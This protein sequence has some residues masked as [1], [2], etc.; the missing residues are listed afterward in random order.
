MLSFASSAR[1]I[2]S[3]REAKKKRFFFA[4]RKEAMER[5]PNALAK[6]KKAEEGKL[7]LQV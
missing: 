2:A 4:S 6:E 1:S 5:R 7:G 3:F